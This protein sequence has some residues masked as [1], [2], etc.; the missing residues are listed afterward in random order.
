MRVVFRTRGS[1]K[2]GMGDVTG[3]LAIADA[4]RDV[5]PQDT[6]TFLVDNNREA[7]DAINARNYKIRVA[8]DLD[9]EITC[10]KK[11]K[12]D[13]IIVNMLENDTERLRNFKQ[14][15]R[16]L[17]TIDDAGSAARLADIRINPLYYTDNAI[18]DPRYI[19]LLKEFIQANN[20]SKI[21][22]EKIEVILI[23]QGGADTYGFIPK[24]IKALYNI[25]KECRIEVIIGPAFQHRDELEEALNNSQRNFYIIHNATNMCEL[26]QRSDMA[27]TA[28]G[29]TMF[30]LACVGIPS[31]VICAEE[32]EEETAE[33][34]AKYG[35]VE[36]LGFGGRVSP[37]KIYQSVSSLM[38]DKERRAD[39]SRRGQD[40][41]DGRGAERVVKLIK[42]RLGG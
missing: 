1:H 26:M 41:V 3:S 20:T 12:P 24:I 42:E 18:T 29:N 27:I 23:T 16:L 15:T 32:F 38:D 13:V 37:Q 22:K 2:Q 35:I 10:L 34:M 7:I 11:I 36:N 33:R 14:N 31:I 5:S 30:E 28:A 17:V 8:A 6:I 25:E 4:F 9:E 19:A 21:I 40:L 39:M